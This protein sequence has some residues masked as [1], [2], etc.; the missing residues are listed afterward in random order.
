[1]SE[2]ISR[3]SIRLPGLTAHLIFWPLI[4]AGLALDLWSKKTVFDWL[5]PRDSFSIVD[6]CLRLVV[7]VNNGAAFGIFSGRPCLLAAVSIIALIVVFAV[8][9]FGGAEKKLVH[10]A[11]GL[12]TAGLC[13]NLYDRIFNNGF[14]RD[15]IDVYY[16]R[17]H[18]PAFNFADAMLCIG[19]VL[20]LMSS[21]FTGQSSRRRVQQ[22]K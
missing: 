12:F 9:F 11:L 2:N 10:I 13:G 17:Y 4:V 22:R 19:V 14:V 5:A 16:R 6:G 20:L 18:W 7:A 1:M 3:C 15:F 8:F 21:V